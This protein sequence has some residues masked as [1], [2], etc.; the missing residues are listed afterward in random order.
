VVV[1]ALDTETLPIWSGRVGEGASEMIDSRSRQSSQR[2]LKTFFQKATSYDPSEAG[3]R[4][5]AVYALYNLPPFSVTL[6]TLATSDLKTAQQEQ[7]S[8]LYVQTDS[9]AK[10]DVSSSSSSVATAS[11]ISLALKTVTQDVL[12]EEFV[13]Q[14]HLAA[15][16]PDGQVAQEGDG[17]LPELFQNLVAVDLQIKMFF[18]EDGT[19]R[20]RQLNGASTTSLEAEEGPD[21]RRQLVEHITLEA[22][23]Y[24]TVAFLEPPQPQNKP[25]NEQV[26]EIF[27]AWMADY[28]ENHRDLYFLKLVQSDQQALKD[29]I[30]LEIETNIDEA[31]NASSPDELKTRTQRAMLL[32]MIVIVVMATT[33]L[34]LF[35]HQKGRRRMERV[36]FSYSEAEHDMESES[37]VF[38]S[39]STSTPWKHDEP[40]QNRGRAGSM[41]AVR[42]GRDVHYSDAAN[43]ARHI[44]DA[45]DRYLSKHRPDLFASLKGSSDSRSK[46]GEDSGEG[47]GS[48]Y[49]GGF[50]SFSGLSYNHEEE[51]TQSGAGHFFG[52]SSARKY[53]IPSN[54]FEYIYS[55]ASAFGS[56]QRPQDASSRQA[57]MESSG[58]EGHSR[59]SFQRGSSFTPRRNKVVSVDE[60]REN[61]AAQTA[62]AHDGYPDDERYY[63]EG[64]ELPDHTGYRPIS[65]IWRNLSNMISYWDADGV[66]MRS[67]VDGLKYGSEDEQREGIDLSQFHQQYQDAQ[68]EENYDFPFQDFPRHDGTPCVMYDQHDA[69]GAP[70]GNFKIDSSDEGDEEDD[71]FESK[72]SPAARVVD[73]FQRILSSRSLNLSQRSLNVSS[74]SLNVSTRSLN[75]STRSLV[76]MSTRSLSVEDDVEFEATSLEDEE[77][78]IKT[79]L[80]R[81]MTQR[82][83][84]YQKRS[85]VEKHREARDKARKEQREYERRERHVAME[86]EIEQLEAFSPLATRRKVTKND[87]ALHGHHSVMHGNK[88]LNRGGQFSAPRSPVD[89]PY[90]Q[91]QSHRRTGSSGSSSGHHGQRH[92]ESP[93]STNNKALTRSPMPQPASPRKQLSPMRK[94]EEDS[95]V[96]NSLNGPTSSSPFRM[97]SSERPGLTRSSPS[98]SKKGAHAIFRSTS[99]EE[100]EVSRGVL[101]KTLS[102]EST[103]SIS[104]P[105]GLES[106]EQLDA[107]SGFLVT[108]H[109]SWRDDV[110]RKTTLHVETDPERLTQSVTNFENYEAE[111]DDY[112]LNSLSLPTI[113][114]GGK[115]P[116][117]NSVADDLMGNPQYVRKA[118]QRQGS[119]STKNNFGGAFRLPRRNNSFGSSQDERN[120]RAMDHQVQGGPP[121]PVRK[122]NHGRVSSA[123]QEHKYYA[124]LHQQRPPNQQSQSRRTSSRGRSNQQPAQPHQPQTHNNR[125]TSSQ[126]NDIGSK[127][128]NHSRSNSLTD[129]SGIA[130][131]GIYAQSRFT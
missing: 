24:G 33:W 30:K 122:H 16:L 47:R 78:G 113:P 19:I 13:K 11:M 108:Q 50:G 107:S 4:S 54:P 37:M 119:G 49:F 94:E 29:I 68:E 23:M 63:E 36:K 62:M 52:G 130:T 104:P 131:H 96:R 99:R 26:R 73:A 97:N 88:A 61:I 125:R 2:I 129:F 59:P 100:S 12:E 120:G 74:R 114:I 103:R 45:S 92:G 65:S 46:A 53:V 81:L 39:A 84:L 51:D 72:I 106:D 18:A 9:S 124:H 41:D 34:I 70:N 22:E 25:S 40:T 66:S 123:H 60:Q 56:Y 82:Q 57:S 111:I 5:L 69:A 55:A 75:V 117:P 1:T 35:F 121:T 3:H 58:Q 127:G 38:V 116:S 95:A 6:K 15:L 17:T 43:G 98:S 91:V 93:K 80:D 79:K 48:F 102:T 115:Y 76:N 112:T 87:M 128:G 126:G 10:T 42:H 67:S 85:I 118:V 90:V 27:G 83:R 32:V 14:I 44:L 7:G 109:H 86:N 28:F 21:E 64:L 77:E 8:T 105:G 89:Q 101:Q 20:H 31:K 71:Q 110:F